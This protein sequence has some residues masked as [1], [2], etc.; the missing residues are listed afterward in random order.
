MNGR[1]LLVKR[2]V[3]IEIVRI[4]LDLRDCLNAFFATEEY[5]KL[6]MPF[7][8]RVAY[9]KF[10]CG[11]AP[12]QIETGRYLRQPLEARIC[13][14]CPNHIEDEQHV[15]LHCPAYDSLRQNLFRNASK[16]CKRCCRM[17]DIGNI[18]ALFSTE[19]VVHIVANT[20]FLIIRKR[21]NILYV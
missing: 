18:K 1:C 10:R 17:D 16:F 5:C 9:T 2:L 13:S 21:N 15:I 19:S 4:N 6:N 14:F 11:V 12:I 3:Q 7:V 8:H 20:C